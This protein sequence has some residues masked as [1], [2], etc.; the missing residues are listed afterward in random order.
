MAV[1]DVNGCTEID[2]P[3]ISISNIQDM[4]NIWPSV[5]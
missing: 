5:V 1:F 3:E 2:S 4:Q